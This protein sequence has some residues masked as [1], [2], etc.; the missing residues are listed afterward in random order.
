MKRK[1]ALIPQWKR[2]GPTA[3]SRALSG[4]SQWILKGCP[5]LERAIHG[6]FYTRKM[7]QSRR[8]DLRWWNRLEARLIRGYDLSKH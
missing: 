7:Q 8:Y 4:C 6:S 3:I 5:L 1:Y 2:I